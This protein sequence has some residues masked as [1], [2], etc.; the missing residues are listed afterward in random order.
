MS[1]PSERY[2][3]DEITCKA[4]ELTWLRS[5]DGRFLSAWSDGTICTM[6]H[7]RSWEWFTFM[8]LSSRTVCIMTHQGSFVCVTNEDVVHRKFEGPPGDEAQ[9]EV[10]ALEG[11][12]SLRNVASRGLLSALPLVS[13]ERGG[14]KALA[15]GFADGQRLLWAD[16]KGYLPLVAS[17]EGA[18]SSPTG[19]RASLLSSAPSKSAPKSAPRAPEIRR[20]AATGGVV[21]IA[22][23]RLA[24]LKTDPFRTSKATELLDQWPELDERGGMAWREA[25]P[26]TFDALLRVAR[27]AT[28]AGRTVSITALQDAL[29]LARPAA[30]AHFPTPPPTPNTEAAAAEAAS[31]EEPLPPG[32]PIPPRSTAPYVARLVSQAL[33]PER[34]SLVQDRAGMCPFCSKCRDD[35]PAPGEVVNTDVVLLRDAGR[36][37]R[38]ALAQTKQPSTRPGRS[39]SA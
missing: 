15:S 5:R 21:V 16:A 1:Q 20:N 2:P 25:H 12:V 27:R 22:P 19:L 24:R 23:E 31:E 14:V 3:P 26:E 33:P 37:R 36:T 38:D 11:G 13:E 9:F 29:V 28:A 17:G 4:E 32:L 7:V 10:V 18:S 39:G 8:V 6:G 34:A 30:G 35:V